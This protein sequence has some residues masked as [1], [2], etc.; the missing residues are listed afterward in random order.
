VPEPRLDTTQKV[1]VRNGGRISPLAL[2][3]ASAFSA[4][5]K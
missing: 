5:R 2:F 3:A 1:A 4:R